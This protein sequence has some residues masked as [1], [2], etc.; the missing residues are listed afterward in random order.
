MSEYAVRFSEL[1]RH[2]PIL[3]SIVRE[4]VRRFIE[5][6]NYVIRFSMAQELETDTPYQQVVEIARRLEVA[7]R[8]HRGYVSH[9]VHSA[10]P[11]SSGTPATPRSLVAYYAPPLSSAPPTRGAFSDQSSQPGPSQFQQSHLPRAC[12]DCGDTPHMVRDCP[13]LRRGVPPK[14]THAPRITEGPQTSQAVVTA[15]VAT[16]PS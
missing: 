12:F 7:P 1:S 3:V 2:A 14:T 13:I 4:Q 10:L 15:P 11:S 16:P 8:H 6:L 5:G 9:L